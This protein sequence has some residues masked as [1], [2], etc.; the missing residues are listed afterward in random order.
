MRSRP[1]AR[2]S[3]GVAEKSKSG[4]S[5]SGQAGL[6]GFVGWQPMAQWSAGMIW[7]YQRTAP[8]FW[9]NAITALVIFCGGSA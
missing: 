3:I 7:L 1:P 9:S 6:S 5:V 2:A 4:P 8:V